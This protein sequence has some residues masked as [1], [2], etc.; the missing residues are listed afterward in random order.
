MRK[1]REHPTTKEAFLDVANDLM[2]TQGYEATA[3][4][5]ICEKAGL[6]KGCFFHYFK[7]KEDLAKALLT[8]KCSSHQKT[9]E[10][11]YGPDPLKRV[12]GQID[13]AIE[14]SNNPEI[15]RGCLKGMLAQE[16]SDTHPEIRRI[17]REH[18]N[19]MAE[20]L[21]E[22]LRAAKARYAP[23]ASFDPL[24]LAKH[25]VAIV[26]GSLILV[27]TYQDHRLAVENIKHFKRYVESLFQK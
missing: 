1:A 15:T 14:M 25:F 22:D 12:Y 10:E 6:T 23:K 20:D 21:A 7:S 9:K 2:L 16:M 17:C 18:F 4:D 27:K 26:Q 5:E 3:I 19:T 8:R 11:L 24:S 13:M